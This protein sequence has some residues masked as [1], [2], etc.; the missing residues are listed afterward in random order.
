MRLSGNHAFLSPI[1]LQY[2]SP[3]RFVCRLKHSLSPLLSARAFPSTYFY[4]DRSSGIVSY[5]LEQIS[6]HALYNRYLI[7]VNINYQTGSWIQLLEWYMVWDQISVKL[8]CFIPLCFSSHWHKECRFWVW[9]SLPKV[10]LAHLRG[11]LGFSWRF[12][13]YP[14]CADVFLSVIYPQLCRRATVF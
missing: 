8:L 9:F 13:Q 5:L 6:R 1:I 2:F 12:G 14:I 11:K 10:F 7:P 3:R 4:A